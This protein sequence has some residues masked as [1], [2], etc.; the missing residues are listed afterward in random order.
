[1]RLF[2]SRDRALGAIIGFG[3]GLLILSLIAEVMRYAAIYLLAFSFG[4]ILILPLYFGVKLGVR[5]VEAR[6]LPTLSWPMLAAVAVVLWPA[7]IYLPFGV[8]FLRLKV[9]TVR[10]I[11]VYPL[12]QQE[13][14]SVE[15]GDGVNHGDRVHL[16]F[17]ADASA[18]EVVQF[19]RDE[20]LGMDWAEGPSHFIESEREGTPYWFSKNPGTSIYI[21]VGSVDSAGRTNFEVIYTH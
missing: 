4:L 15:W 18:S 7:A 12:A 21:K 2:L 1:M 10:E 20:L 19:Y 5:F 3:L 8:Q 13:R 16:I 6:K 11:P 14:T 9:L 17:L